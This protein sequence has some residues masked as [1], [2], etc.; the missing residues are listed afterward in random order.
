MGYSPK[1][2]A[3]RFSRISLA[4]LASSSSQSLQLARGTAATETQ[5][6]HACQASL[7]KARGNFEICEWRLAVSDWCFLLSYLVS[8]SGSPPAQTA[9]VGSVQLS[10]LGLGQTLLVALC[11]GLCVLLRVKAAVEMLDEDLLILMTQ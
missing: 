1:S 8:Q 7:G 2:L 5:L 11:L 6:S 4:E 10:L 3:Q 9:R